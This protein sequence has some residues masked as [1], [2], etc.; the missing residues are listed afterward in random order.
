[1]QKE[2]T[3][4]PTT[5]MDSL[6]LTPISKN[7]ATQRAGRA[8]REAAG[9]C[10]R[11][12]TEKAYNDMRKALLPEIQRCSLAFA[13]LH[14]L[15]YGQEDVTKF[16]F[17]D[18]P[19]NESSK[20]ANVRPC[21]LRSSEPLTLALSRFCFD[22]AV[23]SRCYRSERPHHRSGQADGSSTFRTRTS[24]G[25]SCILRCS[26]L[27]RDHRSPGPTGIRRCHLISPFSTP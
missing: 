24:Q 13:L 6:L 22:G 21:S 25:P 1:M 14:L 8:G 12:Y 16:N 3:Y 26:L 27:S 4:H 18:R 20:S 10:F 19:S 11:L 23:W 2:K 7:S 5:G 9:T 17:M 15:A